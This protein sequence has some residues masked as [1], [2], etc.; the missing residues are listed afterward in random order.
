[1]SG[2]RTNRRSLLQASAGAVAAVAVGSGTSSS[3][4]KETTVSERKPIV[5]HH[6]WGKLKEVVV[7]I[8]NLRLPSKLAD[9]PKRFL[10]ASSVEFIERN[11]GSHITD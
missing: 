5:V 8:P 1:M 6:E 10:P 2:T 7:G 4:A 11:A 3:T 9:A